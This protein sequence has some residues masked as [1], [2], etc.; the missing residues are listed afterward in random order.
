MHMLGNH[1]HNMAIAM[2]GSAKMR[3]A[4]K[5]KDVHVGS[6]TYEEAF[7]TGFFRKI[8]KVIV[9]EFENTQPSIFCFKVNLHGCCSPFF[10]HKIDIKTI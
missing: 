6:I 2:I 5:S 10:I 9:K 4:V 8:L 3:V 7:V 1:L